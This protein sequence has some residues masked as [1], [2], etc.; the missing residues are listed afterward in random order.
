MAGNSANFKLTGANDLFAKL[1]KL[2]TTLSKKVLMAGGRKGANVVRDAA[3]ATAKTIDRSNTP[4]SFPPNIVVRFSPKRYRETGDVLFRVGLLGGSKE[5]APRGQ[6]PRNS[7]PG[8]DTWYWRLV[9]FGTE[10]SRA[11]QFMR[12]AIENNTSQ[13][14]QAAVGEMQK[15][16]KDIK[17]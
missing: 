11:R 5:G 6:D 14:L 10:R 2:P 8:K 17:L 7:N 16:M 13:V 12:P 1:Q 3:I 9:E 4:E 15:R